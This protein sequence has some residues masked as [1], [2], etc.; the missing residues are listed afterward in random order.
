MHEQKGLL[1]KDSKILVLGI[2]FKENCPDIRNTKVVDIYTSLEEYTK[3][4]PYMTHGQIRRA[5]S[6]NITLIL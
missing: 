4:L 5:L 2:T 6:M 1:V 3:I